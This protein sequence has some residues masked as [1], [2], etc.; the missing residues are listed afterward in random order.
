MHPT[1]SVIITSYAPTLRLSGLI[2]SQSMVA[3]PLGVLVK[4]MATVPVMASV[5]S[6]RVVAMLNSVPS[7]S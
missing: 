1:E 7:G 6:S 2:P 5:Q 4:S 3:G